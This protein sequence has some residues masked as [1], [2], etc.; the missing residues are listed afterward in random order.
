VGG[1]A[2]D[3]ASALTGVLSAHHPGDRVKV[4]W[5]DAS[6]QDHSAT[7]TLATGPAA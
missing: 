3:S 4:E 7:V 6:G 2:V 5:V 1:T